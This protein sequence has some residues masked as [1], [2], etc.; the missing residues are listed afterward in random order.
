MET[1]SALLVLCA[2]NSQVTGEFPAQR[3]VTRDFDVYF[4]L[5]LKKKTVKQT[6]ETPVT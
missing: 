3:S 2:G 5:Y 4:D 6:M 1:C